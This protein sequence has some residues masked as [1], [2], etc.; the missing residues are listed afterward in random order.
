MNKRIVVFLVA[1]YF[2]CSALSFGIFH[3]AFASGVVKPVV[4]GGLAGL[5]SPA[6]PGASGGVGVNAALPKTE[7]CPLNGELYTVPE[8]QAWEK[9]RPLAVMIENHP[10]ARPQSGLTSADVVYE[11]MAEGGIT[12]FEA[13]FLCGAQAKDTIVAPVRSA[14]QQFVEIASEYNYPLYAHVGGSNGTDTDPRVRALEHLSD[15]GWT[16]YNDL[17]QFSIGYP[18][19]VRNY[20]RIPGKDL[21]TEHTMEAS[22]NRLWN[23]AASNRKLTNLDKTGADWLK[24]FV[25]WDFADDAAAGE[26]AASQKVDY[27]FWQGQTDFDVTWQY[28]ASTNLYKRSLA[29]Q[30]HIDIN[31]QQQIAAKNVVVLFTVEQG[32]LDI[33]KHIYDKI[34]GGAGKALIF[35]NG[36]EIVG[37]WSKKDRVSRTIFLDNKGKPVKFVRGQIWVSVLANDTPVTVN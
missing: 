13:I 33:H 1:I 15:Y 7:A 5:I 28:D 4:G 22:T 9:R 20:N 18:V 26:R 6:V 17:N 37:T 31:N 10:D 27:G 16:G 24:G 14:R 35:Q 29:G 30:P 32:P 21:A 11:G 34:A 25:K 12:R 23:Y 19:F 8:K 36:K 2:A 3:F